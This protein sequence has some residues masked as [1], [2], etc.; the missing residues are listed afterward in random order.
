MATHPTLGGQY[1]H[2]VHRWTAADEAARL[3]LTDLVETDLGK[4]CWQQNDN[5]LWLLAAVSPEVVWTAIGA[6]NL[7]TAAG[8]DVGTGPGDIPTNALLTGVPV[9]SIVVWPVAPLPTGYLPCDG[10]L[11]SQTAYADLFAVLGTTYGG[12]KNL[13]SVTAGMAS[14]TGSISWYTNAADLWDGD[15]VNAFYTADLNS[16]FN[17]DFGADNGKA[18]VQWDIVH[19]DVSPVHTETWSQDTA[20][21]YWRARVADA[22]ENSSSATVCWC[23][24]FSDDNSSWTV[25]KDGS[26]YTKNSQIKSMAVYGTTPDAFGTPDITDISA[27]IYYIIKY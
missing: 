11:V 17:I 1:N 2:A 23:I 13:L 19:D 16:T 3:A 4:V 27:G 24:E 25:A 8:Y 5:S 18:L 26:V 6:P 15:T 21:R 22:L 9:G 10:S 20:H 7:G 12:G 14:S